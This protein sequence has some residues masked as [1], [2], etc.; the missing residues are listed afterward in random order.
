M[1]TRILII[2]NGADDKYI[3]NCLRNVILILFSISLIRI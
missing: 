2:G 3:G 1:M